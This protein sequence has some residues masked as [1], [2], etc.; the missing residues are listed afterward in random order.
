[1]SKLKRGIEE[2]IAICRP[3]RIFKRLWRK[4]FVSMTGK[5]SHTL[6]LK[7]VIYTAAL[8]DTRAPALGCLAVAV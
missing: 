7:P 8:E 6:M 3:R 2:G 1:M 4:F 5:R